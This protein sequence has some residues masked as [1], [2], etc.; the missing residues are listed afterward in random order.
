MRGEYTRFQT[1]KA[2]VH[3]GSHRT[4]GVRREKLF[5]QVATL[6]PGNVFI[7]VRVHEKPPVENLR[8][9][10]LRDI[11]HAGRHLDLILG[12]TVHDRGVRRGR[13]GVSNHP[14]LLGHCPSQFPFIFLVAIKQPRKLLH[15]RPG[16]PRRG[17]CSG[18][19]DVQV[20]RA[21]RVGEGSGLLQGRNQGCVNQ[22]LVGLG[23]AASR[24][25][26]QRPE[27]QRNL[28]RG[29]GAAIRALVNRI[30]HWGLNFLKLR[31][32]GG[33]ETGIVR[34]VSDIGEARAEL[35]QDQAKLPPFGIHVPMKAKVLPK[36]IRGHPTL[37]LFVVFRVTCLRLEV[38]RLGAENG[39][40]FP[41][42]AFHHVQNVI[43]NLAIR[44]P[45]HRGHCV[46]A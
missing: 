30:P 12:V 29:F 25:Q 36:S 1:N 28:L 27:R 4:F 3:K 15:I 18:G 45:R 20:D 5:A 34:R 46:C 8:D 6:V 33:P 39:D 17:D 23:H 38:W 44:I 22:V 16:P 24:A 40:E 2:V 43:V 32:G 19:R 42:I 10:P 7:S 9:V 21:I 41:N 31:Q 37:L 26:R 35:R 11:R 13:D 14:S